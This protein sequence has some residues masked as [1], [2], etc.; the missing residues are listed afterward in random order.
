[1]L[2]RINALDAQLKK[3]RADPADRDDID[4]ELTDA[5]VTA[6]ELERDLGRIQEKPE[7][8]AALSAP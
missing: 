4:R 7:V 1:M 8:W 5:K 6:R 2:D 3:W